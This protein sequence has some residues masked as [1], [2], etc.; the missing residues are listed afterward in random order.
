MAFYTKKVSTTQ[1]KDAGLALVL[2]CL[3][4]ALL[5]ASRYFLPLG[6]ALLVVSMTVPGLFQPFAKFWFGFS[7]ALGTVMSKVLLSLL[8]YLMVTPVG[9]VRRVMGKDAMQLKKWKQGQA[10]VFQNR[11][12]QFTAKDLDHPY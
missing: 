7:H 3:I 11:D 1:C 5:D 12:H 2:I 6:V 4:L 10:S 9:I 8:F